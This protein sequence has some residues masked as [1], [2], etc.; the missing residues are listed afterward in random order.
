[1]DRVV[2][3]L[4]VLSV[5]AS[6]QSILDQRRFSIAVSRVQHIHLL[7]QKYF[8]DFE[9][10]LQTEDQRQV[11]KIFLQDFCNSDDIISPI[12][13]HDTQ[14]S[15]VLKLLSISVR[16]IESWEF[17]SRFVTWSTFPRNQISHKLSELKTGIRMLIEANQDGAEVF[18][19]SSTFQLAPYGN[20]Y[21]SL[22][23]DESLRRNY[24][25]L[26]CFKKDMHKVETYLTVAKCRLS[27]EANCTL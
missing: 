18:S 13:K 5:A 7:A 19:D 20:F 24:E 6:S 27:P 2:I 3:V 15:S 16:L 22:G 25:L 21:Q 17:S 12:D 26:A 9:S 14:R 10:S 23:G 11:N 8:S 1:M 4:S